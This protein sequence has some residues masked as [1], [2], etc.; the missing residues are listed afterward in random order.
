LLALPARADAQGFW[1]WLEEL[2]GPGPFKDINGLELPLACYGTRDLPKAEGWFPPWVC[3]A[4]PETH[5]T[6]T[7][8]FDLAS[9]TGRN[10]LAYD[11]AV[12]AGEPADVNARLY[13]FG[14]TYH[15]ADRAV[16]VGVLVGRIRLGSLPVVDSVTR[17]RVEPRLV[18][19][20]LV[21]GREGR[22]RYRASWLELRFVPLILPKRFT[23]PDLGST[24]DLGSGAEVLMSYAVLINLAPLVGR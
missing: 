24:T 13:G 12:F 8:S 3:L 4:S 14:L 1:R 20:P 21:F 16:D 7:L 5:P 2:S 6:F 10:N 17:T 18:V 11:P 22:D 15:A 23:G 9:G 19:R